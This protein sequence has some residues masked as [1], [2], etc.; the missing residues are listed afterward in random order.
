MLFQTGRFPFSYDYLIHAL[1]D[2]E[3]HCYGVTIIKN[4]VEIQPIRKKSYKN[5]LSKLNLYESFPEIK[6][7]S[8]NI[9]SV[10]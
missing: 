9:V 10:A 5:S 3:N 7:N 4:F 8:K 1:Y 6:N 2:F